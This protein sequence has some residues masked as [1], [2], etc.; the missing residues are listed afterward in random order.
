MDE[1]VMPALI[2]TPVLQRERGMDDDNF[3][4]GGMSLILGGMSR[5]VGRPRL[6]NNKSIS[7]P[8]RK[9]VISSTQTVK[10]AEPL[11]IGAKR[12]DYQ[13]PPPP[14][15]SKNKVSSA[16]PIKLAADEKKLKSVSD[17][18]AVGPSTSQAT[19]KRRNGGGSTSPRLGRAGAAS[20]AK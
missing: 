10:K 19:A 3:I 2:D 8:S 6:D 13:G 9:S 18:Y 12:G 20:I 14:R 7:S 16:S 17:A 4:L 15:T 5:E 11:N 1:A